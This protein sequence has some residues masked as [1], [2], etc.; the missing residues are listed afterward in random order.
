MSAGSVSDRV[1]QPGLM[2]RQPLDQFAPS[3]ELC[4]EVVGVCTADPLWRICHFQY[5]TAQ[6][7]SEDRDFLLAFLP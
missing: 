5:L 1:A 7:R 3:A 4:Q 2:V 6:L